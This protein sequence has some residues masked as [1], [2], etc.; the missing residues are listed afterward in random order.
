VLVKSPSIIL[1]R[2]PYS[3]SSWVVKALTAS[4]GVVSFLVKGGKRREFAFKNALD[5]LS[6]SEIVFNKTNRSKLYFIK[7]ASL[8]NW[9]PKMRA[10]LEAQAIGQVMAEVI[11]R[12]TPQ[13]A[14]LE[15]EFVLLLNAFESLG[16]SSWSS[17]ILVDWLF[18]INDLWGYTIVTEYCVKCNS[19]LKEEPGDFSPEAG[20]AI[21]KSCLSGAI[22][23]ANPLFLKDLWSFTQKQPLLKTTMMER[24]FLLYLQNHLGAPQ[25]INSVPWLKEVRK[26]CYQ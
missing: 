21:C 25:E 11:L 7:E 24:A 16:S 23:R 5:P 26:L 9:F 13:E 15:R 17:S 19:K 6:F 2:Y 10:N 3:E 12:Y 20:G 8:L 1:H 4:E 22:S 18:K 14:E